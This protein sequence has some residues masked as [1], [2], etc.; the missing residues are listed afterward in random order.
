M[1]APRAATAGDTLAPPIAMIEITKLVRQHVPVQG[2]GDMSFGAMLDAHLEETAM[3]GEEV[4]SVKFEINPDTWAE[5]SHGM[6]NAE[7]IAYDHEGPR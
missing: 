7:A 6:R 3:A 2:G 1:K 5:Y 4:Q